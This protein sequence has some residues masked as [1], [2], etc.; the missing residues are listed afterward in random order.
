MIDIDSLIIYLICF[1]LTI[2]SCKLSELMYKKKKKINGHI[3]AMITIMLPCILAAVRATSVGK[4]VEF[5]LIP[6]YNLACQTNSF[7]SFYLQASQQLEFLFSILV[8]VCAK[9]KNLYL[10]F[11][12]IELFILLPIYIFLYKNREKIS[13]TLGITLYLFLF[14]NFSLSGMR[15]SIAMS[16]VLLAFNY[17]NNKKIF[18]SFIYT[19][20]ATLFHKSAVLIALIIFLIIFFE[21]KKYYKKFIIN[22]YILLIFVFITYNKFALTISNLLWNVSPRYS[23]YIIHYI[24]NYINWNN[25]P[26]TEIVFKTNIVLISILYIY[27]FKKNNIKNITLTTLVILGR[28]FV[29]FNARFYESLRIAYYFDIFNI[30]LSGNILNSI[31]KSENKIIYQW[32]TIL[33]AFGYWIYFIMYIGGYQTHIYTFR[34]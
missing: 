33:L 34:L 1:F 29:L 6:N 13:I 21:N 27:L 2:T 16:F 7:M 3:Y 31:N 30:V 22:I 18:K 5:Y 8:Y 14:Y 28:Y 25:I 23:F 12:L 10:L 9:L 4:D 24:S 15:Q 11:F 19:I 32:L 26:T 20:I 17:Y